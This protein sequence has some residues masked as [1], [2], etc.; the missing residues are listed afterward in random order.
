[1][2]ELQLTG[3]ERA[4]DSC[5][6]DILCFDLAK[7]SISGGLALLA[8]EGCPRVNKRIQKWWQ[9]DQTEERVVLVTK[10]SASD[11]DVSAGNVQFGSV[12]HSAEVDAV[13]AAHVRT[14]RVFAA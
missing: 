2:Y 7:G 8:S 5:E 9:V 3:G 14:G 4:G 13:C 6:R 1:M 11:V 12:V 10:H